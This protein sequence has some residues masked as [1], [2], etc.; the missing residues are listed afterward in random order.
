MRKL[1]IIA[2]LVVLGALVFALPAMA[3]NP[4][5]KVQINL[6]TS[7][8]LGTGY[9]DITLT[10]DAVPPVGAGN[11]VSYEVK[12][13]TDGGKTFPTSLTV[14]G[15]SAS[16]IGEVWYTDVTY[17]IT[18]VETG[19][20]T[21]SGTAD[22]L[23]NVYPP[24]TN[25][26]ANFTA[27]TSQCANCHQTHTALG[28]KLLRQA[29]SL[30]MC[31]SCHGFTG[32]NSKY[33]VQRGETIIGAGQ[34]AR[35]LGGPMALTSNDSAVWNNLSTTSS[36]SYDTSPVTA[37]G[38]AN[39]QQNLTCTSC[40]GAHETGNYR[41]IQTSITYPTGVGT[42]TKATVA[43]LAAAATLNGSSSGETASYISGSIDLCSAC[44]SD[45]RAATGSGHTATTTGSTFVTDNKYRH[46]VDISPSSYSTGLTTSLPLEG[47]NSGGSYNLNK[48]VCLTC[49]YAHGTVSVGTNTS[50]IGGASSTMLKRLDNMG[51]CEDCHKK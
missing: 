30:G 17:K 42:T 36:H 39:A 25:A 6:T 4:V 40:H 48:I 33:N 34:V 28:S 38:G 29:T 7:Q 9:S 46:S 37:P 51:V 49:H 8:T 24:D 19:P 16:S 5:S 12:K 35:S 23:V 50:S 13:S 20:D 21:G 10:W 14:S 26:H 47:T 27:N 15:L 44:H 41:Q 1:G 22:K 31:E 43:F 18:V 11:S 2:V 32:T 3:A 45:Y